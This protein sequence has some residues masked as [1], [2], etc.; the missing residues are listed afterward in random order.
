MSLSHC[1]RRREPEDGLNI[2]AELIDDASI[3]LGVRERPLLARVTGPTRRLH[4]SDIALLPL[5]GVE[6]PTDV[7]VGYTAPPEWRAVGIVSSAE[8]HAAMDV[9]ASAMPVRMTFL[10]ERAGRSIALLTPSGPADDDRRGR[11]A[12]AGVAEGELVDVCRRVLGL[13]T[14]PPSRQPDAWLTLRWLDRLLVQAVAAPRR[15]GTWASAAALHPLVG[16][17]ATPSPPQVAELTATVSDAFGWEQLRQLAA[18]GAGG[19]SPAI[20]PALAAW[21]DAGCFARWLLGAELPVEL[22]IEE[23]EA[24]LRPTVLEAVRSALPSSSPSPPREPP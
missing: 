11:R 12:V 21:M 15:V 24:L 17:N 23:L 5:D 8:Q 22:L 18:E 4:E 6:H 20:E 9:A 2:L 7:L 1:R 14:S 13:P 16:P 3:D 19:P 10:V